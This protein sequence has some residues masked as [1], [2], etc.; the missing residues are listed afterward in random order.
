MTYLNKVPYLLAG[1]LLTACNS[2]GDNHP[3]DGAAGGSLGKADTPANASNRKCTELAN[4]TFTDCLATSIVGET[5]DQQQQRC[6]TEASEAR[7]NCLE[8]E[9]VGQCEARKSDAVLSGNRA[10]TPTSIRWACADVEGVNSVGRDDRGQ[11]YCEYFAAIQLPPEEEDAKL[12]APVTLG[13]NRPVGGPTSLELP[14]LTDFQLEQL[15]DEEDMVVGQ[16]VFTSWHKDKSEAYPACAKDSGS[17]PGC[18]GLPLLPASGDDQ[19]PLWAGTEDTDRRTEEKIASLPLTSANMRMKVGFNSNGAAVDLVDKCLSNSTSTAVKPRADIEDPFLRGCMYTFDLF[20]TQW[21]RSDAS[22]CAGILRLAE[23]GC[24][25]DG[26]GDG[27]LTSRK[28]DVGDLDFNGQETVGEGPFD[29]TANDRVNGSA[30]IAVALVPFNRRG[31]E[32]A[33]WGDDKGLPSGCKFADTG[34]DSQTLVA[35]DITAG[36]VISS[37]ELK[38]FCRSTYGNDVVVH[39]PVPGD[40]VVCEPSEEK[41]EECGAH[42]W[43]IGDENGDQDSDADR[44]TDEDRDTDTDRDTEEDRDTDTDRDANDGGNVLESSRVSYSECGSDC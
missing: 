38:D 40:A 31:F 2:T 21:R 10:Y 13:Q 8:A 39:I 23:C 9:A 43:V 20:T 29:I 11:E 7:T 37:P 16:C 5:A 15:E 32:L 6:Q 24:G 28:F 35:C 26:D 4:K 27:A 14:E 17:D 42:P 33:T 18:G 44:D 41:A 34:D 36:D 25:V 3:T 30:E 12:P 1:L 22:I 19:R